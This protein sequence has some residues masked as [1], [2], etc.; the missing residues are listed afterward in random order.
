MEKKELVQMLA[1]EDFR[2][3]VQTGGRGTA[4]KHTAINAVRYPGD[5]LSSP[6]SAGDS[7]WYCGLNRTNEKAVRDRMS[8]KEILEDR[9]NKRWT[10]GIGR[11]SCSQA[12]TLTSTKKRWGNRKQPS[13]RWEPR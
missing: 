3:G 11:L 13:K 1:L 6:T 2:A 7:A 12:R 9:E 8:A 10:R 5:Y 4:G